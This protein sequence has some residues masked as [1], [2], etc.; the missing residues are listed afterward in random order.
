MGLERVGLCGKIRRRGAGTELAGRAGVEGE[1]M[2]KPPGVVKEE[3]DPEDMR[4]AC[5]RNSES[6]R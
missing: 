2:C 5:V 3:E 1:I 6:R 4:E